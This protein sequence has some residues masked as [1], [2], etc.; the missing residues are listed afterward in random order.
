[1]CT[2]TIIVIR[3]SHAFY[4]VGQRKTFPIPKSELRNPPRKRTNDPQQDRR[5]DTKM[6]EGRWVGGREGKKANE[7]NYFTI[8]SVGVGW[9]QRRWRRFIPR[10]C[11]DVWARVFVRHVRIPCRVIE[12]EKTALSVGRFT[13]TGSG[14]TCITRRERVIF[15]GRPKIGYLLRIVSTT[16]RTVYDVS[17]ERRA[18]KF[19]RLTNLLFRFNF[20]I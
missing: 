19:I 7:K 18:Y 4:V 17:R 20:K 14:F 1:M 12:K 11:S 13:M 9:R 8:G 15:P 5:G 6:G 3:L 2:Y 16:K 10:P